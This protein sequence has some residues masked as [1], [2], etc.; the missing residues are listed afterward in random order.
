MIAYGAKRNL[1]F[2]DD[3]LR[4]AEPRSA[5]KQ[6]RLA[7]QMHRRVRRVVKTALRNYTDK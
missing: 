2:T 1:D 6:R 4:G 3:Y 5:K 7:K